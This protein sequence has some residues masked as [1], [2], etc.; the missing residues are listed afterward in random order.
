MLQR[1]L[2]G[3]I[4]GYKQCACCRR[5][6]ERFEFNVSRSSFDGLQS[7]CKTCQ[8]AYHRKHPAKEYKKNKKDGSLTLF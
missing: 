6:K 8:S 3:N 4:P 5:F 1:N 7:Y 2:F